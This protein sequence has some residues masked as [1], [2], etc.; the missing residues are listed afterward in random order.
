MRDQDVNKYSVADI[1]SSMGNGQSAQNTITYSPKYTSYGLTSA[2]A[3]LTPT[4]LNNLEQTF[5]EL[6]NVPENAERQYQSGFV[7]PPLSTSRDSLSSSDDDSW[8]DSNH[9]SQGGLGG[10]AKKLKTN[11]RTA[12]LTEADIYT[13][14]Y[15]ST[16]RKPP[17]RRNNDK[18]TGEEMTRRLVRRERNKVAAAKCR[19]RRVDHTNILL[20]ETD[21]LDGER[22]E[23]ENEIQ[24]LQQQKEHLEFLLQAH[25]PLCKLQ[26]NDQMTFSQISDSVKVKVEPVEGANSPYTRDEHHHH[27]LDE[28]SVPYTVSQYYKAAPTLW[29]SKRPPLQPTWAYQ[30]QRPLAVYSLSV[31]IP[32]WMDIPDSRL[33]LES[34]APDTMT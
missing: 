23:I 17:Q 34:Q 6:Q 27:L 30:S 12:V 2:T 10:P 16:S 11:S 31:W 9:G 25:R 3:T 8:A 29:H 21:K 24:S 14:G 32:W 1:L 22:N 18:V 15:L 33:S 20:A 4:T 13:P 28:S 19:Q 7:P 26:Q 5:I